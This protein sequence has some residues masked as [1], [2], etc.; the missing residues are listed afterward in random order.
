MESQPN[1]N[2]GTI[3]EEYKQELR[4][5]TLERDVL[6]DL[7]AK[8]YMEYHVITYQKAIEIVDKGMF[9]GVAA[10]L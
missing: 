6:R 9:L 3:I 7:L 8:A 10:K 1:L 2:I 4:R 5:I